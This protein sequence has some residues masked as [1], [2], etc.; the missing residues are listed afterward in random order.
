M[1]KIKDV[2][3]LIA[4]NIIF[5]IVCIL[6]CC[7]IVNNIKKS[8]KQC[9]CPKCEATN[10][11][12]K[13]E[14]T[15]IE[16]DNNAGENQFDK[17]QYMWNNTNFEC[18]EKNDDYCLLANTKNKIEFFLND[19]ID[20]IKI[21]GYSYKLN[22]GSFYAVSEDNSGNVFVMYAYDIHDHFILFDSHANVITNFEEFYD[23]SYDV[24]YVRYEDDK[25][26]I[27]SYPFSTAY[28]VAYCDSMNE[29]DVFER[30][31]ILKYNDKLEVISDKNL[32]LKDIIEIEKDVSGF[33]SCKEYLD[34]K[35]N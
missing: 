26:I 25:Y 23:K 6:S 28:G 22:Q 29:T 16:D 15:I 30:E 35:T 10:N 27:K 4:V 24:N 21:N 1:E 3:Y 33:A 12:V 2:K 31:K 5:I 13:E 9:D 20:Q 34:S 14:T 32:T 18:A 19:R 7:L 11:G 8:T 17:K